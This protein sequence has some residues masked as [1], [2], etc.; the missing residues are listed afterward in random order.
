MEG[1]LYLFYIQGAPISLFPVSLPV[2]EPVGFVHKNFYFN[3][4][5]YIEENFCVKIIEQFKDAGGLKEKSGI[6]LLPSEEGPLGHSRLLLLL[7]SIMSVLELLF[8]T[9]SVQL[10]Q[11]EIPVV[12][13]DAMNKCF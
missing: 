7:L 6:S 5:H 4:K 9:F 11:L 2:C 1:H 12:R 8:G 3:T 13:H 10:R